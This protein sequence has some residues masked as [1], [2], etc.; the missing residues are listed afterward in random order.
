MFSF[1]QISAAW[2][3]F[4]FE[5]IDVNGTP[6]AIVEKDQLVTVAEML[7]DEF[8]FNHIID[9]ISIDRFERKIRF[10]MTYNLRNLQTKDRP[11]SDEDLERRQLA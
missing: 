7:R 8:G 5:A 9:G 1:D 3:A 10:E 2:P 6:G 4:R 11:I